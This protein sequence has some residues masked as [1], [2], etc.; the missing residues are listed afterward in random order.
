MCGRTQHWV[1]S[2]ESVRCVVEDSVGWIVEE[3]VRRVVQHSVGWIIEEN[4]RCVL[5]HSSDRVK[6]STQESPIHI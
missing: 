3:S 6:S 4:V 5:E 2:K 1:D